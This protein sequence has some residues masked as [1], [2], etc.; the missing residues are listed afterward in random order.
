LEVT[1]KDATAIL[2]AACKACK[3][4]DC[5]QE[6]GIN[7]AL[8]EKSKSIHSLVHITSKSPFTESSVRYASATAFDTIVRQKGQDARL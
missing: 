5:I 4:D 7:S 1:K 2:E 3:L 6:I 8:T